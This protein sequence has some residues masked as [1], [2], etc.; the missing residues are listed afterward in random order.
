MAGKSKK[1]SVEAGF[2]ELE[3]IGW[4]AD[5]PKALKAALRKHATLRAYDDDQPVFLAGDP[6]EALFGIVSGALRMMIP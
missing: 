2:A 5:R 1:Q 6:P 3:N 4:L